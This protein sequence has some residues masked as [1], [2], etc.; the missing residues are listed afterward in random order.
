MSVV[1]ANAS[2]VPDVGFNVVQLVDAGHRADP[3]L[4]HLTWRYDTVTVTLLRTLL[5]LLRT[6]TRPAQ[7]KPSL[8]FYGVS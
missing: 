5:L 1:V 6:L 3:H 4:V 8:T 2:S 7:S